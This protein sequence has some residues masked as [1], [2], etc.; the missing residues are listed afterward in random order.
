MHLATFMRFASCVLVAAQHACET[1]LGRHREAIREQLSAGGTY[2]WIELLHFRPEKFYSDIVES[3]LGAIFV[4]ADGD[5]QPCVAFLKTI[6]VQ[7]YLDRLLDE[8]VDVRSPRDRVQCW[9]GA[10]HIT[11]EVERQEADRRYHYSLLLGDVV[12]A[13]VEACSC[14]EAA[15][16]HVAYQ[17]E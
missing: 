12:I 2:P 3:I 1:R 15:I 14:R 10:R 6:G 4:D 7:E 9:A 11:Y 16:T 8:D 5:L 17:A 13:E